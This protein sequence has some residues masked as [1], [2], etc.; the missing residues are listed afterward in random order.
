MQNLESRSSSAYPATRFSCSARPPHPPPALLSAPWTV[1]ACERLSSVLMICKDNLRVLIPLERS[2]PLLLLK[3]CQCGIFRKSWQGDAGRFLCFRPAFLA[4]ASPSKRRAHAAAV[5]YI[6]IYPGCFFRELE[7]NSNSQ[8]LPLLLPLVPHCLLFNSLCVR[9]VPALGS[10]V[11][12]RCCASS[13]SITGV[14]SFA[15]YLLPPP[16]AF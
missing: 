9:R 6:Y 7:P 4:P 1:L 15:V 12:L 13:L 16:E 3:A 11:L 2:L 5:R 14:A 10:K 8:L